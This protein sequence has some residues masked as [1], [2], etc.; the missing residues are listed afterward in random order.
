NPGAVVISIFYTLHL[1]RKEKTGGEFFRVEGSTPVLFRNYL[2]SILTGCLWYGQF[3]FYGVAHVQMG[4]LKFSSWAIHMIMMILF[5]T[6]L[7]LVMREWHGCRRITIYTIA[8]A[9]VLLV[10]SVL[11][12]SY[13]NYLGA[14]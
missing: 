5:S 14:V 7:G 11:V 8:L 3:L 12:L 2:L 4:E 1:T 10:A 13:G 6:V 9:I